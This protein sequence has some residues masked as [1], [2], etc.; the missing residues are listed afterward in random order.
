MVYWS[1]EYVKTLEK[2]ED[3][4]PFKVVYGS[5]HQVMPSISIVKVGDIIYPVFR[6]NQSLSIV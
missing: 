3:K 6:D 1:K 4:G 2:K 5:R